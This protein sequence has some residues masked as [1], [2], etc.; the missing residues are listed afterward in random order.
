[1]IIKIVLARL[2]RA[3]TELLGFDQVEEAAQ[4]M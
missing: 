3:P 1:M 4:A 2:L